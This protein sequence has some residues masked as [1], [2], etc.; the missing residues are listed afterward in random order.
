VKDCLED[1]FGDTPAIVEATLAGM[2]VNACLHLSD[3]PHCIGLNLTGLPSD[4]KTTALDILEGLPFTYRSDKFS[5]RAFVSH[6]ATVGEDDLK[7]I[8]L[9]PRI[10]HKTI[11]VPELAPIFEARREDLMENI[12]ILTRVFDGRGLTIDSG[13]RGQRGYTGDYRFCWLAATTP[14]PHRTWQ[15]LGKLG[16]RW[17]FLSLGAST[18]MAD[19]ELV[20]TVA[21]GDYRKKIERCQTAV[22]AYLNT[23]WTD[24][25][26]YGG[27][28]WESGDAQELLERLA[29]AARVCAK[30]R[31]LIQRQDEHGYNPNIAE[32]P[33]RLMATLH[34]LA[35]GYALVAGRTYLIK[36]DMAAVEKIAYSSMPEDRRRIFNALEEEG[37]ISTVDVAV[38]GSSVA[39][40]LFGQVSPVGQTIRIDGKQFEV[41]GVLESKGATGFGNQDDMIL[42]PITTMQYRL[43][44]QR[45]AS[46]ELSVQTINVQVVNEDETDA[47]IQEITSILRDEHRIGMGEEDDFNISSQEEVIGALEESTEIWV[48]LLGAIAGISLLVGG[49]GVMNI[50]LVSVTERTREIGIRKAVGAKQRDILLQFL[51]EATLMGLIGGGLGVGAGLGVTEL[52]SGA[53]LGGTA[54][55]TAMSGDIIILAVSVAV[56]VGILFG[57]WPAYRAARLHPIEAL[58]YE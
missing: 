40:T 58:R 12:S 2:A 31:G 48:V 1:N 45:T 34:C 25:G 32:A 6:Y 33:K 43:S 22:H 51:V 42:I 54:I 27:V 5:P 19:D 53:T 20:N 18:E 57:L 15:V 7:K 49:I 4:G 30:W 41:I 13:T 3:L 23:L 35:R 28:D 52:V 26:G 50:M 29:R 9:L 38:L 8:D 46:G 24:Y 11:L 36:E 14:L 56:G 55:E 39:E 21:K 10:A 16:S 47:A 44:A 37:V 17:L